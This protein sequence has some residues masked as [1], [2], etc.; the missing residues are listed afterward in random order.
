MKKTWQ[1][2]AL[3]IIFVFVSLSRRSEKNLI[4]D[5]KQNIRLQLAPPTNVDLAL[6][7]PKLGFGPNLGIF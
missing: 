3:L 6:K 7:V 1:Q 5:K 4:K 2:Q